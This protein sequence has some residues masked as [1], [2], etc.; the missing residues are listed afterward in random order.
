MPGAALGVWVRRGFGSGR[1]NGNNDSERPEYEEDLVLEYQTR[2]GAWETLETFPGGTSFD[3]DGTASGEIFQ[4]QFDLDNAQLGSSFRLR[5]RLTGGSGDGYDYW[6]VDDVVVT[7]TV[8]NSGQALDFSDDF[9]A[10]LGNWTLF[11]HGDQGPGGSSGDAGLGTNPANANSGNQSLYLGNNTAV[12]VSDYV[13]TS[14][15]T[16]VTVDAWVKRGDDG[17]PGSN[18]PEGGEDLRLEYLDA[19]EQ[20]SLLEEFPGNGADGETFGRS[21][22]LSG[23]A[24]HP[25]FR[26]RFRQLDGSGAGAD[27]WH[28][29]DVNVRDTGASAAGGLRAYYRMDATA[30]NGSAGEVIDQTGNGWDGTASGGTN[31]SGADPAIAGADGTCRYGVFDGSDDYIGVPNLSSVL[32]GS[33]SMTFWVKVSPSLAGGSETYL[34]PGI[35]GVEERGGVDDIFWGWIDTNGRIGVAVGNDDDARSDTAINDGAWHHIGLSRN[36]STGEYEVYIDGSL[37][38]SGTT[39]AGI[40]GNAYSS[41]GRIED[42]GGGAIHFEGELDEVR[43]YDRV[44][45]QAQVQ[46]DQAATHPCAVSLVCEN[47]DFSSTLGA[48]WAVSNESGGFGDPRVVNGALRLTDQSGNVATRATLLDSIPWD[49]NR[50]EVTLRHYAYGTGNGDADGIAVTFSDAAVTPDPGGYG[51]SLGYAQRN[52]GVD[53][54]A[55]GWLGIAL[56]EYGNF[57]N[58]TEGREGGPGRTLNS[59]AVRGD[60]SGGSGYEYIAGTGSLSPPVSAP[61]SDSRAPGHLYRF[62][63][64]TRTPGEALVEVQRDT[65]GTGSS[66]VTL[67]S[68]DVADDQNSAAPAEVFLTFTGAT[69]GSA[70]FHEIDELE[71]CASRGFGETALAVEIAHDNAAVTCQAEPV[72]LRIVDDAG[73]RVRDFT[74]TVNL[75]TSTGNGVWSIID[76]SA[77]AFG[78]LSENPGDDDGQ[79]SYTFADAD[80]GE[81]VLGLR[82]TH[83]EDV[84]IDVVLQSDNSIGDDDSEGLLSFAEVGFQFLVGGT[85]GNIG[86]QIGGKASDVA[87]GAQS[88]ELEAIRTNDQTG[89]CEAAF[90]GATDVDFRFECRDPDTCAGSDLILNGTAISSVAGN[91]VSQTEAV[92]LDFG[93]AADTTAPVSFRYD[94]VGL[95]RLLPR[96][97]LEPNGQVMAGPSNAFVVRPFALR[98]SADGNP[99]AVNASGGIFT[100]AGVPFTSRV[101]AVLWASADDADADG[102]ADGHDDDDPT[103]N[104]DLSGNAVAPNFGNEDGGGES[105]GLSAS[106]QL[107]SGG[108]NP[109]LAAGDVIAGFS[110]GEGA[111]SGTRFDE[112]GIIELRSAI[113]DGQYLGLGSGETSLIAGRSGYV[114][115]FVPDRFTTTVSS[116]ST[117]EL[118][119][120][121]TA[122]GTDF[123]YTGQAFGYVISPSFTA[124]A[125]PATGASLAVTSNYTGA[126][127]KLTGG[128]LSADIDT[129]GTD[130]NSGLTWDRTPGTLDV[131]DNGDGTTDIALDGDSF[132]YDKTQPGA[133]IAPFAPAIDIDVNSYGDGDGVS[134]ADTP[135][136]MPVDGSATE[137]RYGRLTL[138]NAYG[139]EMLPLEMPVAA[140]YFDGDGYIVNGADACTTYDAASVTFENFEGDLSS[141]DVAAYGNG[142]L[143]GGV[144]DPA[145]PLVIGGSS[146]AGNGPGQS[147]GVDAVLSVPP[148]LRYDWDAAAVGLEDPRGR[149]NFGIYRG[150]RNVIYQR[151]LY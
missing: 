18:A 31:T 66:F 23:A 47:R 102:V 129:T 33:A 72:T 11:A 10:G 54:F 148:Y 133:E 99:G 108:N 130:G 86:T 41:I 60:G 103:N 124:T 73:N 145:N 91:A 8:P 92:S 61:N 82:N 112:V 2:G 14:A 115:R 149:A 93:D 25:A 59:V 7:E 107:P 110:G 67:I 131:T 134:A 44:I 13:D 90:Q 116:P 118:A 34:S 55:G 139:S 42:T 63:V 24:L 37:D 71:V 85:P 147:G 15:T 96:K 6:H 80:N 20:W 5:F 105:A 81:A 122:G 98:V 69:G 68:E 64:D 146:G 26:L 46:A 77:D 28:I 51:G 21:Y 136:P 19:N 144:A 95:I 49:D 123:S 53:G 50:V 143:T 141:G 52:G 65:T 111:N 127:N 76:P 138:T 104:A 97:T 74:G 22:T 150:S 29:D 87:P 94:D 121:C 106:L 62:V 79:A 17:A 1:A 132:V 16:E 3:A 27:Y 48:D 117:G 12:A 140:E 58:P 35:A 70:N 40:I 56:D 101:A 9:E 109:G 119:P 128:G 89:A 4:R 57:S 137:I 30:W 151:E 84:D 38:A 126:F 45:D 114:G 88:I 125:R 83:I 75:S 142:T 113:E 100:T 39:G 36:A 120:A 78:T 32:N 135:T 43:I